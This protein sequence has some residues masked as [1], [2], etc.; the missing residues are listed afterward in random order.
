MKSFRVW[1]RQ[2]QSKC[3]PIGD[4]ACD[5]RDDPTFPKSSD[6]GTISKYLHECNV[7]DDCISTFD[8]AWMKFVFD[9]ENV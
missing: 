2:F 5:I 6:H 9:K 1:I 3:N 4:L 7:C 8:D